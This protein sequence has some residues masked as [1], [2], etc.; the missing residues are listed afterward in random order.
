MDELV[1]LLTGKDIPY[2]QLRP[3]E[4][5]YFHGLLDKVRRHTLTIEDV[6]TYIR[7]L[8]EAVE[9]ELTKPSLGHDDDLFLKARLRN[10]MLLDAML[11]LPEKAEQL[12]KRQMAGQKE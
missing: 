5:T 11:T 9:M 6:R 3:D 7:Q 1:K 12:M 8:R 4:K 10:L 2:D